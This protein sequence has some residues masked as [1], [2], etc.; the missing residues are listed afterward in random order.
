[1]LKRAAE[2]IENL[3]EADCADEDKEHATKAAEKFR[4]AASL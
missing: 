4:R 2:E 3:V 1:L